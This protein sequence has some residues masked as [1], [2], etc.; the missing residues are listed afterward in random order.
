MRC[1]VPKQPGA[2]KVSPIAVMKN[3]RKIGRVGEL[4]SLFDKL[5][6]RYN[7]ATDPQE[8]ADLKAQMEA[9]EKKIAS[10]SAEIN[11][12]CFIDNRK[13]KKQ[14]K[15]SEAGAAGENEATK[16]VDVQ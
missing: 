15:E 16:E 2:R 3:K 7:Q 8:R 6:A 11:D 1:N 9:T 10:M 4:G 14:G 13:A 5:E 12:E